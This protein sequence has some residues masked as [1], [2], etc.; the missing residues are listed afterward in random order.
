METSESKS[1]KNLFKEFNRPLLSRTIRSIHVP[2][3]HG[4]L[5]FSWNRDGLVNSKDVHSAVLCYFHDLESRIKPI[6]GF[7][8]IPYL[9]VFKIAEN[10]ELQ[11]KIQTFEQVETS[12]EFIED[13][14]R[15]SDIATVEK[16]LRRDRGLK[17]MLFSRS[18]E[19]LPPLN[20]IHTIDIPVSGKDFIKP[21]QEKINEIFTFK[22]LGGDYH[23]CFSYEMYRE[24]IIKGLLG[25]QHETVQETGDK[26]AHQSFQETVQYLV[27]LLELGLHDDSLPH[28]RYSTP[29]TNLSR[30]WFEEGLGRDLKPHPSFDEYN[31]FLN[32]AERDA[33]NFSH[34]ISYQMKLQLEY[35]TEIQDVTE[36]EI[37]ASVDN[38][39]RSGYPESIDKD[40]LIACL[41][42]RETSE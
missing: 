24:S 9:S 11:G 2:S 39:V 23:S 17:E 35:L 8:R 6:S 27:P 13:F 18:L 21:I 14:L 25:L 16:K 41:H 29:V 34:L 4:G 28:F 7:I 5:G 32:N 19:E 3:S 20:F 33:R 22:L 40:A 1:I 30:E 37:E 26:R 12:K 31:R 10:L 38:I 42:R 36:E 15:P